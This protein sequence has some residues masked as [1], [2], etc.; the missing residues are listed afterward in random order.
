M[1][2][3]Q[4]SIVSYLNSRPFLYGLET[5][6]ATDI[7]ISGDV[8][9]RCAE[10]LINNE[11]TIGLVPVVA[12]PHI[13][14]ARVISNFCLAADG[15]VNSVFLFA[16]KPLNEVLSISMDSQSLTSNMLARILASRYWNISPVFLENNE[17]TR[18]D[19]LVVIG[20]RTF[21]RPEEYEYVYDLAG[22][23]K[24][25][26]GLPFVFAVWAANKTLPGPFL[27]KFNR[28]LEWGIDNREELINTLEPVPGVDIH[29]YLFNKISFRLN[30]EKQRAMNIFLAEASTIYRQQEAM[31]VNNKA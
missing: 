1:D 16:K 18:A 12:L 6:L 30:E 28:A 9:S 15:P 17:S 10:K 11:V 31:L 14:G 23:W 7:S 2:K 13:P 4:V 20:D 8:P 3:I 19:A 29:D 24:A 5:L 27:E 22:E 26:T 25:F 21:T